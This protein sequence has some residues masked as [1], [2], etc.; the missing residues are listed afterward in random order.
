MDNEEKLKS[1]VVKFFENLGCNL[2]WEENVL[3][4]DKVPESFC[5]FCNKK[6][7]FHLVFNEKNK[8]E[9]SE[10]VA[11]GKGIFNLLTRYLKESGNTTLLK[12]NFEINPVEII[13]EHFSFKNA[14]VSDIKVLHKYSFFYRFTFQTDF[15]Y[16]NKKEKII[17]EVYVHDKKIVNGDLTGYPVVEG[18]KEE[19]SPE[20]VKENYELAKTK[21]REL[22]SS[23]KSEI[24]EELKQ[25]LDAEI[26]RVKEYYARQKQ[27]IEDKI[28]KESDRINE[29]RKPAGQANSFIIEERINKAKESIKKLMDENNEE[30]IKKEEDASINDIMQ[31]VSLNIENNLLNTT[32]IYHPL[33]TFSLYFDKDIKKSLK[34]EYNPLTDTISE[35]KCNVCDNIVHNVNVCSKGHA[36]CD[37]CFG[38]CKNCSRV[39]CNE[40]L[41]K[42]CDGCG[43]Y[44]CS[45]C[46][47]ICPKCKRRICREHI[48][49]DKLNFEVGCTFCLKKCPV[50]RSL[51]DPLLFKKNS[52]GFLVCRKCITKEVSEKIKKDIFK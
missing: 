45:D 24:E 10:L 12:I 7:P 23:Q 44:I 26:K 46:T 42:K 37:S 36:S 52:I 5:N 19:V 30:K 50:C 34:I 15:T 9:S 16:M 51:S 48:T 18:K 40:C 41:S 43:S 49:E 47:V 22:V 27:E 21:V 8:I 32:V 28:N 35:L 1:F 25:K 39:F 29:I 14:I 2:S 20:S 3:I 38:V 4:V 6:S 33:F 17:N 13:R 31:K 11:P